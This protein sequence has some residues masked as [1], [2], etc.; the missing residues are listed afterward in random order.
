MRRCGTYFLL[1]LA[2]IFKMELPEWEAASI[3]L[4]AMTHTHTFSM[5]GPFV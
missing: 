3:A 2:A 5:L 4:Y 1:K